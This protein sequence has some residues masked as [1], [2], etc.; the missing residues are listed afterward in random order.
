MIKVV[1]LVALLVA[2]LVVTAAAPGAE[3]SRAIIVI[4]MFVLLRVCVGGRTQ[5]ADLTRKH[6]LW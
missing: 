4:V 2:P 6:R 3:G 5:Q 1:N